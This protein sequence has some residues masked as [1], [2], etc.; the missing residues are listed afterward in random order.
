MKGQNCAACASDAFHC[1]D[2]IVT[3]YIE[4]HR[5]RHEKELR[6]YKMQKNLAGAVE[7][8]S[9]CLLP[10]GNKHPHQ[11]HIPRASL[12][13]AN[14]R[15]QLRLAKSQ[16]FASFEQLHDVVCEEINTIPKI[17]ALTIYDIAL[18]I[19]VKLGLK[20]KL[21]FLH[22]GTA[23]GAGYL[24]FGKLATL[25]PQ[26]LPTEFTRL[27]PGE[28]EDCLCI[29]KKDIERIVSKKVSL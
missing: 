19:G 3:A 29:F 2:D 20:P 15:L 10:G 21:V 24:G 23:V 16:Q 11:W 22:A 25:D 28:I 26:D 18:R 4:M 7:Q 12:E 17:G 8:A 9:L 6:F 13:A 1:L 27:T 5:E 14:K